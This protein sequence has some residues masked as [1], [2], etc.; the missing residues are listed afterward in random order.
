MQIALLVVS[1]GVCVA[2]VSGWVHFELAVTPPPPGDGA[3]A[4]HRTCG[5]CPYLY[6]LNPEYPQVNSSG[7]RGPEVHRRKTDGTFR[8]LVLG[9]SV[10]YGL[11]VEAQEAFPALLE[12]SVSHADRPIEVLNAAVSGYTAWSELHYYLA[13]GRSFEADLVL[14]VFVMNDVVNPRLHWAYTREPLP[15]IPSSAIPN[16]A[17]DQDVIQPILASEERQRDHLALTQLHRNGPLSGGLAH[18]RHITGEDDLSID[19]L[20]D[21]ESAEWRWLRSIYGQLAQAVEDDGAR[22]GIIWT[23]LAYQLDPDYPFLPQTLFG[24]YCR[25]RSIPC[26]DLLPAMRAHR[27]EHLFWGSLGRIEDI[28]HLTPQGH[29][30]AAAAIADFLHHEELLPVKPAQAPQR[31]SKSAQQE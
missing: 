9:D 15:A 28:W 22:F 3:V 25:E 18:T 6:E 26:L 16:A 21:R 13:K 31:A 11:L 12:H 27:A 14:V 7:L 8:I 10:A 1:L 23:P 5:T 2:L 19:V 17:Y 4:M 29:V 24:D 30:V 20:L